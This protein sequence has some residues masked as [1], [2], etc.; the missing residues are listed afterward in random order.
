MIINLNKYIFNKVI[1]LINKLIKHKETNFYLKSSEELGYPKK[2]HGH[3]PTN[4]FG[5]FLILMSIL[6]YILKF[7]NKKILIAG[8]GAGF[9]LKVIE[10]FNF[11]KIFFYELNK[12]LFKIAFANCDDKKVIFKNVDVLKTYHNVDFIYLFN[13]FNQLSFEQLISKTNAKYIIFRN[14]KF[15]G[16]ISYKIVFGIDL[17][18]TNYRILKISYS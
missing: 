5:V 14:Y 10:R 18:Y 11:K 4:D 3:N 8:G 16:N 15:E 1:L 9:S 17:Y 2:Y 7:K 13:P 6:K 12:E